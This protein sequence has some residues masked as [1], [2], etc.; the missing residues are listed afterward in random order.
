MRILST[1]SIAAGLYQSP[2][3]AIGSPDAL[4]AAPVRDVE[5]RP[6]SAGAYDLAV[7]SREPCACE[8]SCR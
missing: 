2:V 3:V 1:P 8:K 6:S 5:N 7:A 4:T